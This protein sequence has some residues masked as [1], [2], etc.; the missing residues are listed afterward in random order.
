MLDVDT[1]TALQSRV[2]SSDPTLHAAG[3]QNAPNKEQKPQP[4]PILGVSQDQ[5]ESKADEASFKDDI[6]LILRAASRIQQ[7]QTTTDRI[8][9]LT[10]Q[11]LLSSK[12]GDNLK[13]GVIEKDVLFSFLDTK[14]SANPEKA[15]DNVKKHDQSVHED[16]NVKLQKA[17]DAKAAAEREVRQSKVHLFRV[18]RDLLQD[19]ENSQRLQG[20]VQI[21]DRQLESITQERDSL[22]TQLDEHKNSFHQRILE[23]ETKVKEQQA[24]LSKAIPIKAHNALQTR[25]NIWKA[26]AD[27]LQGQ[28][29]TVRT[30]N[31]K[32]EHLL[33]GFKR[34]LAKW[35]NNDDDH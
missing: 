28:L 11:I 30:R 15:N 16:L 2:A 20:Q 27:S 19:Q 33:G 21:R 13:E 14:L 35:N 7:R 18:E 17:M 34:G 32:M 23:L 22:K 26:R 8:A 10:H 9:D 6:Q 29:Q 3:M 12:I 31:A 24:V 1:A 25:L 5:D 4:H